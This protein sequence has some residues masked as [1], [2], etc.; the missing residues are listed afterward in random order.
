MQNGR[1][2]DY[3]F[4]SQNKVDNAWVRGTLCEPLPHFKEMVLKTATI[5]NRKTA[6]LRRAQKSHRLHSRRRCAAKSA[7][8]AYRVILV[9]IY[10]MKC[11]APILKRCRSFFDTQILNFGTAKFQ[12]KTRPNNRPNG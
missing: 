6:S 9:I 7:L 10:N 12:R 8:S 11:G 2:A 5:S 4:I 1:T 3:H